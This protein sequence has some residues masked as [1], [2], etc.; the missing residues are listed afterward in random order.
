VA[1]RHHRRD[2]GEQ[3]VDDAL[4]AH[5]GEHPPARGEVTALGEGDEALGQRA[6]PLGLR[7]GR[8]DP[9]V[10]EQLGGEVR[11]QQ[12]LVRRAAAEARTLGGRGHVLS[13]SSVGPPR[14]GRRAAVGG[15]SCSS[16]AK[17][18]SSSAP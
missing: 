16:S 4:V 10:G 5:D 13:F 3:L 17:D 15:Q 9:A 1:V 8:R 11:Q 2:L 6:H 7:L 14:L 18:M 12:P